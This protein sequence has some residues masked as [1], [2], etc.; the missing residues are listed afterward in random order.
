M[1][2][3]SKVLRKVIELDISLGLDGTQEALD[4]ITR[5]TSEAAWARGAAEQAERQ[6]EE[7]HKA[8]PAHCWRDPPKGR[9]WTIGEAITS[10]AAENEKLRSLTVVQESLIRKSETANEK[11]RAAL[12]RWL[13]AVNDKYA[14]ERHQPDNLGKEWERVRE[15]V[16]LAEDNARAALTVGLAAWPGAHERTD[17]WCTPPDHNL[18]LPLTQENNDGSD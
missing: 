8:I 3:I 1:S 7:A 16:N 9:A 10:L 5:L 12:V 6:I 11:L 13:D 14:F 18:I 4:E 15:A 17:D 2:D